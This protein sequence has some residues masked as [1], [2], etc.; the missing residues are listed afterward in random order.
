MRN[1]YMTLEKIKSPTQTLHLKE[2]SIFYKTAGSSNS[3]CLSK[4]KTTNLSF[5][6]SPEK[7][8]PQASKNLRPSRFGLDELVKS[9]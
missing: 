3:V 2:D 1:V 5:Q 8:K 4:R 9:V 6:D 7:S